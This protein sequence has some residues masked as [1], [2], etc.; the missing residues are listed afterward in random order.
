VV[1]CLG[2]IYHLEN[3]VNALRIARA[4]T[5]GLCVIE[6][7]LAQQ[8]DP[9]TL[10]NGLSELYEESPASWAARVETDWESN[11][12]ASAGGVVSFTPNR[13]ALLQASNAAGF[14]KREVAK[15][16]PR[17]IASTWW[18]TG[19]FCAQGPLTRRTIKAAALGSAW[20]IRPA[21]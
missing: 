6:S 16:L 8:N 1:L 11:M 18:G 2:L 10:G 5:K 13:A 21:C 3:P 9:I 17:I 7:Q 20:S 19:Q 14:G 15:P 12:L 4:L